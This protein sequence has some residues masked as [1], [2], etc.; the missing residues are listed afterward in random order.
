MQNVVVL[1]AG[2]LVGQGVIEHFDKLPHYKLHA[3]TR[4]GSLGVHS[5]ETKLDLSDPEAIKDFIRNTN[6]DIIIHAAGL[7]GF[8]N[9]EKNKDLAFKI[10]AES[11]QA[12]VDASSESSKIVLYSTNA[13]Y[14]DGEG[15]YNEDS[16]RAPD[17]VYGSSK[18]AGEDILLNSNRSY[19]ILRT[20]DVFGNYP[21]VHRSDRFIHFVLSQ[22]KS[23]KTVDAFAHVVSTPTS[24]KDLV[25]ATEFL[26][27]NNHSGVYNVSGDEELNRYEYAKAIANAFDLRE[28]LV[29]MN[30]DSSS[31]SAKSTL[32]NQK[33]KTLGFNFTPIRDAL[34]TIKK[35]N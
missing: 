24:L 27:S 35:T 32:S 9:C 12:I 16:H 1:G 11:V 29:V 20:C 26:L 19:L 28:D 15:G 2:G 8:N 34:K 31:F 22:L 21:I 6:P 30:N 4:T 13:V 33:I 3:T 18:K 10:N 25:K 14:S 7:I 23:N 17:K 5:N